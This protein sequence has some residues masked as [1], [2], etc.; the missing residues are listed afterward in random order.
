MTQNDQLAL[1]SLGFMGLI[2]LVKKQA[3]ESTADQI[4]AVKRGPEV[5]SNWHECLAPDYWSSHRSRGACAWRGGLKREYPDLEGWKVGDM[6]YKK[7]VRPVGALQAWDK[8]RNEWIQ[9]FQREVIDKGYRLDLFFQMWRKVYKVDPK[10][11]EG[12][13]AVAQMAF[14]FWVLYGSRVYPYSGATEVV[15]ATAGT[16][17]QNLNWAGQIILKAR[18][19][20]KHVSNHMASLQNISFNASKLYAKDRNT[21]QRYI[22][23]SLNKF[24]TDRGNFLPAIKTKYRTLFRYADRLDRL[25]SYI[26]VHS[27]LPKKERYKYFLDGLK[28]Y[29]YLSGGKYEVFMK[30]TDPDFIPTAPTAAGNFGPARKKFYQGFTQAKFKR[31]GK[32]IYT[33]NSGLS[34]EF[35]KQQSYQYA[36]LFVNRSGTGPNGKPTALMVKVNV[37]NQKTFIDFATLVAQTYN[38]NAWPKGQTSFSW[39]NPTDKQMKVLGSTA[40]PRAWMDFERKAHGR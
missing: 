31:T 11:M 28:R 12:R 18:L 29:G 36:T 21:Y 19:L 38:W 20:P 5:P 27:H 4:N 1:L 8:Y 25:Y 24:K 40:S 15:E 2:A 3:P 16:Y 37:P 7:F 35:I 33:S 9:S 6:I 17:H 23:E 10:A 39:L 26:S 22:S 32:G 30:E 13:G 34:V 14:L